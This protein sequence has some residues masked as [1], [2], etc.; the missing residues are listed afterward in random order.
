MIFKTTTGQQS[1]ITPKQRAKHRFYRMVI[2]GI[3]LFI[4][5]I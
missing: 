2:I 1:K 3:V 4:V 5:F